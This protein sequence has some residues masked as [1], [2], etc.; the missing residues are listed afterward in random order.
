VRTRRVTASESLT[1]V[2]TTREF[3]AKT[4]KVGHLPHNPSSFFCVFWRAQAFH[5]YALCNRMEG[6]CTPAS[7]SWMCV[8]SNALYMHTRKVARCTW[9]RGRRVSPVGVPRRPEPRQ[10]SAGKAI[11]GRGSRATITCWRVRPAIFPSVNAF[12]ITFALIMAL[13]PLARHNPQP[14][15]R[16]HHTDAEQYN[17]RVSTRD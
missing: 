4:L 16:E 17:S 2:I 9:E 8:M 14:F 15:S 12:L 13:R 11:T 6:A 5:H 10:F 1:T 3:T 7:F